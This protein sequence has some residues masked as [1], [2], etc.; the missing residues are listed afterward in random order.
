MG[1]GRV[2]AWAV[3]GMLA[4]VAVSGQGVAQPT[5]MMGAA[6]ATTEFSLFS[7]F[8]LA[9]E[10]D[11]AGATAAL[12]ARG[13]EEFNSAIQSSEGALPA[14]GFTTT[15]NGNDYSISVTQFAIYGDKDNPDT[16]ICI[17]T[18]NST[19]EASLAAARAWVAVPMSGQPPGQELY[20]YR[21]TAKGR[22]PL[23][24]MESREA[25]A[26]MKAGEYRQFNIATGPGGAEL[27]FLSQ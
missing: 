13:F 23:R 21:Q 12:R 26:A 2:R 22:T 17:V 25:R 18:S 20:M 24:S 11:Y 19:E 5:K 9:H 10:G 14:R 1:V 27:F 7:E 6:A 4:V 15:V 8:C 16:T 3:A